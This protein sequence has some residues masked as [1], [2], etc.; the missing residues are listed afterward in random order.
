MKSAAL[1]VCTQDVRVARAL[2]VCTQDSDAEDR[3]LEPLYEQ[4]MAWDLSVP[5]RYMTER[6]IYTAAEIDDVEREY[7]RFLALS[8]AY[9]SKRIP[10]AFR[11]DDFWHAHILFTEDYC[12]LGQQLIGGYI[13]HRPGILDDRTKLG[14]AFED[15]TLP[16]YQAHFGSPD[17]AFWNP[18]FQAKAIGAAH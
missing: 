9:P 4:L 8:L 1:C 17:P 18:A 10:V 15:H 16:L 7:K 3:P 5:K 14:V 12:A 2:C 11:V 6:G 13:H